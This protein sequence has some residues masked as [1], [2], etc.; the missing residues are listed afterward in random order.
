MKKTIAI[1]ALLLSATFTFAQLSVG[2]KGGVNYAYFPDVENG[3]VL[4]FVTQPIIAYH[5]GAIAEF[6]LTNRFALTAEV[7]Y[8]VKGSEV[9]QSF[10]AFEIVTSF[11]NSYVSIPLA[12]KVKVSKFGFLAGVEPSFLAS[13]RVRFND[14][15]WEPADGLSNNLDFSLIGGVDARLGK[16]YLAARYIHG[17]S[18]ALEIN[19]T[20]ANG[21]PIGSG[22]NPNR[23]F[24]VSAGYFF[25][26]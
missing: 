23:V 9:N 12:A 5:L 8:S 11:A 24:Q 6:E 25:L 1:F 4:N 20:D 2:A 17:L 19:F 3:T 14:E 22:G 10:Q 15:P 18:D 16:L 26:K 13:E 21:N 7:L